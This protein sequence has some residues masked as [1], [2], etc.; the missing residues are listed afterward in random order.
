MSLAEHAPSSSIE[1]HEERRFQRLPVT[2]TGRYMLES[3]SEFPCRTVNMSPG[4][5]TLIAPVKARVGEKVVVYLDEIGRL[6]GLAMRETETGFSVLM[7][8]P[9][10]KR[11]K[12][13]DQI[14]WFANRYLFQSVEDRRH[15]RVVP[16][17]Q[18]TLMRFPD[19][20]ETIVKIA[21][22]SLSGAGVETDLRPEIGSR[23]VLGTTLAVIVR[24]Y[25]GGVGAEFER[26]FRP[27][28]LDE[29]TRL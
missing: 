26:P 1:P 22:M 13:A 6:T 21:D 9:A 3:F 20:R 18:R 14:T 10:F 16:L 28:E 23:I 24:H 27:G 15:T 12:L 8:L 17:M 29:S 11:D 5:M 19:G 4:D 7:N 25:D 2:L